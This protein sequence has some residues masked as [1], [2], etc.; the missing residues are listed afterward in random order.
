MLVNTWTLTEEKGDGAVKCKGSQVYDDRELLTL[1]GRNTTNRIVHLKPI[2]CIFQT[3]RY[4]SPI[5]NLGRKW[6]GA[7]YSPNVAT[8][9]PGQRGG[10]GW[11]GG[12]MVELG[13]FPIFLL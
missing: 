2:Y 9:C 4:T 7:S 8:W 1:G 11:G 6:G 3:I 10:A 12:P 13:F 5:P